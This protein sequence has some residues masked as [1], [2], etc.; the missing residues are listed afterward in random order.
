MVVGIGVFVS[1]YGLLSLGLTLVDSEIVSSSVGVWIPNIVT[2]LIAFWLVYQVGSERVSSITELPTM[3][4]RYFFSLRRS[5]I[6]LISSSHKA[7]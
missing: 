7:S 6:S 1:Y 5:L 2:A 4:T 3:I